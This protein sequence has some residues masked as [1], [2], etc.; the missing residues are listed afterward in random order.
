MPCYP[1]YGLYQKNRAITLREANH[2][3][4]VEGCSNP[5]KQVHRIDGDETNHSLDNLMAVCYRCHRRFHRKQAREKYG[6]RFERV[7]GCK[8]CSYQ[9]NSWIRLFM[10]AL[11]VHPAEYTAVQYWLDGHIPSEE[12]TLVD[13]WETKIS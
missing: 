7:I 12:D 3:C 5:G 1:N 6:L 9:A 11:G 10:H 2:K 13:E 4:K 8:F